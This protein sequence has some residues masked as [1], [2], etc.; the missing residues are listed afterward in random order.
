MLWF[1]VLSICS[2]TTVL[3]L[4]IRR[5]IKIKSN[6]AYVLHSIPTKVNISYDKHIPRHRDQ[7][8]LK[9]PQVP[10]DCDGIQHPEIHQVCTRISTGPLQPQRINDTVQYQEEVIVSNGTGRFELVHAE[11]MT[12]SILENEEYDYAY[13]QIQHNPFPLHSK[14]ESDSKSETAKYQNV[15]VTS[16]ITGQYQEEVIVSNGT[17]R[18]E[19]VHAEVMTQSILENEEYD[20]AYAQI[21]H[22]PFPLHSKTESDSKSETAKYQNVFVTSQITGQYQEEVIVSNGTGRFELVH[23]EVMTQS[24]LE[25]EEYDY[26]YAQIQHNPFPLHSK[27]ESDS[28]SET[29]KY[30]NVFVT[31][32]ITGSDAIPQ[33]KQSI[34]TKKVLHSYENLVLQNSK[35]E[36]NP[37]VM[38]NESQITGSDAI[39]RSKR[40]IETKKGGNY[41]NLVLQNSK[42][43]LNPVGMCN[44]SQITGSD[45]IPRSKR[46]SGTKKVFQSYENLVLQNSKDELN[47]AGMCNESTSPET[48]PPDKTQPQNCPD[49]VILNSEERVSQLLP[50]VLYQQDINEELNVVKYF[51]LV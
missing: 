43:E 14:T 41:E 6:P 40:N 36:L 10:L 24:I 16:Q 35:D 23:A 46:N 7:V 30:Q 3:F 2:L 49:S 44:E 38:C 31:S 21:Q 48:Q 28:K 18:F 1:T 47:P 20:Y 9:S 45:A 25:N 29:A 19:L 13:A 12:Q 4:C 26:A 27:T 50:W 34:G 39:P 51:S 11:V 32:Q 17:G 8:E 37:A 5:R 22:N 42:D 15:F 33:S